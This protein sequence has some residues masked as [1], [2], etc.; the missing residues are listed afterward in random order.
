MSVTTFC[1]VP[2]LADHF[3]WICACKV[4]CGKSVKASWTYWFTYL[5]RLKHKASHPSVSHSYFHMFNRCWPVTFLNR[6]T[7]NLKYTFTNNY[8]ESIH[9]HDWEKLF[10]AGK[11]SVWQSV[12]CKNLVK[13]SLC[14]C[15]KHCTTNQISGVHR[16]EGNGREIESRQ[17]ETGLAAPL[18]I[19]SS[20][21]PK[22]S[23]SHIKGCIVLTLC[24]KIK[25]HWFH[26]REICS[27]NAHYF[28]GSVGRKRNSN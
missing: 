27:Y 9:V 2:W 7:A 19:P 13:N 15:W 3:H 22:A 4:T 17:C 11:K 26:H 24:I 14:W 5:A 16:G 28:H 25:S 18:G 6:Y 21:R 8:L 23:P 10:T 20:G 1:V 12:N